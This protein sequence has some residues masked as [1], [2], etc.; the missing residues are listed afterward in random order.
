MGFVAPRHVESFFLDQGSNL[1]P[2]PW[3]VDSQPLDHQGSPS[4]IDECDHVCLSLFGLMKE[5]PID[6]WLLNNRSSFLMVMEAGSAKSRP[7]HLGIQ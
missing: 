7:R 5:H 1:R 6:R 3:K 4:N 2:P